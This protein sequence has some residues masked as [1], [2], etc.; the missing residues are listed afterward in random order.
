MNGCAGWATCPHRQ[1]SWRGP[2]GG[3]ACKVSRYRFRRPASSDG[4]PLPGHREAALAERVNPRR[5]R[6]RKV[7]TARR[8]SGESAGAGDPCPQGDMGRQRSVPL[9]RGSSSAVGDTA[10]G[11][12][13]SA[14]R[15]EGY[16]PCR[17]PGGAPADLAARDAS[18]VTS[19]EAGLANSEAHLSRFQTA[20]TCL[21]RAGSHT[22]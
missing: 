13:V 12:S 4:A 16:D 19:A 10:C 14:D 22:G 8:G 15:G 11:G 3:K 6:Y 17:W 1:A 20:R 5:R 9:V 21:D 18:R 7:L 2:C